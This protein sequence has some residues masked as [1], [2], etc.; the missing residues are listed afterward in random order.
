M[1]NSCVIGLFGGL[2]WVFVYNY[3]HLILFVHHYAMWLIVGYCLFTGCH[4]Y[5][6]SPYKEEMLV[7]LKVVPRALCDVC[8]G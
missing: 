5:L 3:K 2:L 7:A 4:V 8:I 6:Y 1:G